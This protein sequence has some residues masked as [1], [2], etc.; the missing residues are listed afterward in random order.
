[1]A[2]ADVLLHD[3][4][5]ELGA[6][7]RTGRAFRCCRMTSRA[8]STRINETLTAIGTADEHFAH[9][10]PENEPPF[11]VC[12]TDARHA[13]LTGQPLADL[14]IVGRDPGEATDRLAAAAAGHA[15][16]N[17]RSRA[18]CLT[19]LATLTM[20]T[21]DPI[22]A[23]TMGHAAVDAAHHLFPPRH[24]RPARTS[25]VRHPASAPR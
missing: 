9:A 4:R 11:L 24:R 3:N 17:N 25:P 10:T 21:G 18:V 2:I 16:G 14:A 19:K 1:L 8:D 15:S 13:Q 6:Q 20:I 12:Y 5:A 23:A 7:Q 22:Q